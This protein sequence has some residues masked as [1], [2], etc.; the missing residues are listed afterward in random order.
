MHRKI[1][2]PA[3]LFSLLWTVILFLHLIFGFTILDQLSSLRLETYFIIFIGALFFSLSSFVVSK[4]FEKMAITKRVDE[5]P[6]FREVNTSLSLRIIFLTIIIAGLPFYIQASY[7]VFLASNID[8]FFVGLR[9][10]LSYGDEDIGIT[11]YLTSFSFVVFAINY[12]GL[13]RQGNKKNVWL[14]ILS[15]IVALVYSIFATGRTY[16]FLILS[17]YVGISYLLKKR[18]SIKKYLWP[19]LIFFLLFMS[20]GIIYNKGADKDDT[21]KENLHSISEAT[22]IYLVSSLNAF[23]LEIKNNIKAKYAGE[24]TLLFFVKGFQKFDLLPNTK[25]GSLIAEFVFVPYPTNV[26][27]FYS[28]YIRDFG[29]IYA[30]LMIGLFGALHTWVF[31]KASI[32]KD[33]RYTVYY[34]FLLYPLLMSFFQDQYMSLISTW[35]QIVF[36]TELFLAI[37]KFI[38]RMRSDKSYI[39]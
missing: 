16:Y 39:T 30:W 31:Y 10:E 22:A 38:T 28:P 32:T 12:Y 34:S 25:T 21:L 27:T 24:N 7:R 15:F 2:H 26:Y 33:L 4:Y 19:L 14:A 11:K 35:L 23:D 3:V 13:L 8:N 5:P 18:F 6:K 9:T 17:I 1:M 36:Y 20:I 29:K 37:N